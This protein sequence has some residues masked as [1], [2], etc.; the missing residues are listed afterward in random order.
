MHKSLAKLKLYVT[1]DETIGQKGGVDVG[2]HNLCIL[3][4]QRILVGWDLLG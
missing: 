3:G 4:K 2:L 1:T